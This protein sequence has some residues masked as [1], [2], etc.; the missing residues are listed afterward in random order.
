MRPL[1]TRTIYCHRYRYRYRLSEWW[2][3][4]L[5]PNI[6]RGKCSKKYWYSITSKCDGQAVSWCSLSITITMAGIC[7]L[8]CN[9]LKALSGKGGGGRSTVFMTWCLVTITKDFPPLVI[10][11]TMLHSALPCLCAHCTVPY[12]VFVHTAQCLTMS[13]STQHSA[14]RLAFSAYNIWVLGTTVWH[15]CT[16]TVSHVTRYGL[17]DNRGRSMPL[18]QASTVRLRCSGGRSAALDLQEEMGQWQVWPSRSATPH[19]GSITLCIG[20]LSSFWK[21]LDWY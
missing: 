19:S 4:A 8:Q 2:D 18:R 16:A 20:R 5:T 3:Q 9:T 14:T 10:T 17:A 11:M 21:Y 13:L 1:H 15:T 7:P 6:W 12:H